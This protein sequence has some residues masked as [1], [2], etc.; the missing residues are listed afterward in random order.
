MLEVR[1]TYMGT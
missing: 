1:P